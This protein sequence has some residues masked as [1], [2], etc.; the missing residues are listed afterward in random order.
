MR[1]ARL[2][3]G[4][5][6]IME[7][8]DPEPGYEEAVVRITSAGV[9]HSDVHLLKGDWSG[10]P[11]SGPFGHEGIG[12]VEA[13]G[14]GGERYASVGD[15][16]IVGL[17]GSGGGYWCGACEHC[18]GGK[19]RLCR[20]SKGILGTYSEQLKVFAKS[21]VVLPDSIDDREVPLACGGL[22]AY[23][24]VKKLNQFSLVP[25]STVAVIGAAGG[26]GHYAVQIARHWGYKVVGA[27][28]GA[29]KVDFVRSL[30]AELAVDASEAAE[31][32]RRE[33]PGGVH[34]SLVFSPK[35]AGF[36]LGMDLLR[37]G[38]LFIAVGI[39]ADDEGGIEL[40]PWALFGKDPLIMFSAVGTVQD[41]RE[42]VQLAADGHVK[43][44]VS[45]TGTLSELGTILDELDAGAYTGRAVI[46]DLS[47]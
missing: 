16:V 33:V 7:R 46:T 5:L 14:P 15:R 8:P 26:L 41:M 9:C 34:A 28:V 35:L 20:Q 13:L 19:P 39:P 27:D 21:L 4:E 37:R 11:R 23:G 3:D 25:G 30:G 40:S 12:I 22:T 42:L 43:T 36:R 18:L 24:A 44:H 31:V 38:G 29:E 32:V 17:G 1:T 45:R 10:V 2:E 47:H 6:K